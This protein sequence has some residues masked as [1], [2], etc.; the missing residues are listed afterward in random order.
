MKS[1]IKLICVF[2]FSTS[3]AY[4]DIKFWTTEVQPAR[5]A[6]QEEMAKSFEPKT[7]IKV[8]EKKDGLI[9]TNSNDLN[10]ADLNSENDHRL[11]MAFCIA[12]L[13]LGDSTMSDPKSVK[14]SFPNFISEMKRLGCKIFLD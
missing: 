10:G 7:G 9:L 4:A 11:F 5:M 8:E 3:I 13:Y 14:V 6:K 12:G 1:I 2:I